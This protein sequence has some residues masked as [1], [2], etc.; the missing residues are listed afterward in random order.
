M[1]RLKDILLEA[2]CSDID[3]QLDDIG[4]FSFTDSQLG[5][6]IVF[7]LRKNSLPVDYCS[8]ITKW[9]GKTFSMFWANNNIADEFSIYTTDPVDQTNKTKEKI[10]PLWNFL[11]TI[12]VKFGKPIIE[13][14]I[15]KGF[16]IQVQISV[17]T[18]TTNADY[19]THTDEWKPI[20]YEHWTDE[21]LYQQTFIYYVL[22]VA[23]YLYNEN[24]TLKSPEAR[25]NVSKIE[26]TSVTVQS[27]R[28][29]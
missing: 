22:A 11:Q 16:H 28:F 21:S 29:N 5:R 23:I 26:N 7:I 8:N 1:K 18:G 25:P 12:S 13:N 20:R 6:K 3:K 4:N 17:R 19:K 14:Q 2:K 15:V 27:N 9:Q 24:Y 10:T